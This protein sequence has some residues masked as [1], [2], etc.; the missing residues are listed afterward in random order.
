METSGTVQASM[1]KFCAMSFFKL[2]SGFYL[3]LHE[4]DIAERIAKSE[5]NKGYVIV[6][7]KASLVSSKSTFNPS[8]AELYHF[9]AM[10]K[11]ILRKNGEK[12]RLVFSTGKE[13]HAQIRLAVFLG[14]NMIMSHGFG[15]QE[16]FA[17][18]KPIHSLLQRLGLDES[19]MHF[20]RALN[21]A[22][23]HQWIDFTERLESL[24][25]RGVSTETMDMEEY[26][27]YARCP[28]KCRPA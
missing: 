26:V 25:V 7:P 8:L 6:S 2:H 13:E 11:S 17:A 23:L 5:F 15:Y 22:K 14:C 19:L 24:D 10:T 16:A 20:L 28:T 1:R 3:A 12:C 21:E 18:L 4:D 9:D 27:H